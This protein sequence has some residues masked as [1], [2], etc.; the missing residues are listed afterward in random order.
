MAKAL[1]AELRGTANFFCLPSSLPSTHRPSKPL[2]PCAARN[3][4]AK[5]QLSHAVTSSAPR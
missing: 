2:E 5:N 4:Q 1:R 3:R